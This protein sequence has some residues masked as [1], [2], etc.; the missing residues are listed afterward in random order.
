MIHRF[1]AVSMLLTLLLSAGFADPF[2]ETKPE[3]VGMSA[4]RL[5]R[6]DTAVQGY[7]DREEIAGAVTLI[8]RH[9]KIAHFKAYG[10]RDLES[11]AP[12]GKD[13][14]FR[15]FSMTKPVTCAALMILVEENEI[16]LS[17]PVS[18]YLPE[19]SNM[20]VLL[21]EKDGEIIT[22]PAKNPIT[23][24]NLAMHTS[25][26]GYGIPSEL[27][28]LLSKKYNDLDVFNPHNQLQN[29]IK[30]IASFPVLHQPGTTWEYGASIDVLARVV[31]VVAKKPYGEFL[32]ERIFTPLKMVDS[33]FVAPEKD[34]NRV[35]SLYETENG[36][37]HRTMKFEDYYKVGILHGGGSGL[38]SSAM[39]YARFAQ[40][41][42]NGGELE[43]VRI[44]SPQSIERMS[45]DLLRDEKT[46][47]V[48]HNYKAYGFGLGVRVVKD[49][50]YLDT[51][52]SVGTW[53]WN[54]YASTE[55]FID[56]KKDLVSVFLAQYVPA[57]NKQMWQ[58]YTNKVYQAIME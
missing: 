33:G 44:L 4:E 51:L 35:A 57:N 6:L 58:R 37:L 15:M 12:M 2:V 14:L 21:Q 49:P 54:G 34:W 47:T 5:E 3:R 16:L 56:P 18:K 52:A 24:Q 1:C 41:L 10:Y 50:A 46:C 17:D 29:A 8:A 32:K 28:P 26:I 48:W 39:D 25:G 45:T 43:G 36:H 27:S 22:E 38:V 7:I 11:K 31:E 9:G 55:F 30:S 19:F 13:S 42:A 53:G 20:K 23:I 40:M